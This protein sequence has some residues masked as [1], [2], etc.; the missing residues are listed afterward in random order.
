MQAIT[1][2]YRTV[3]FTKW[4]YRTPPMGSNK[5]GCQAFAERSKKQQAAVRQLVATYG[6]DIV[7]PVFKPKLEWW[8]C[9]INWQKLKRKR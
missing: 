6:R 1:S 5:G 4:A 9:R 8:D 3:R 2:G 7:T